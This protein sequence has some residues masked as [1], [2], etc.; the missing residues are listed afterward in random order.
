[1]FEGQTLSPEERQRVDALGA[2]IFAEPHLWD[3]LIP[4]NPPASVAPQGAPPPA[5]AR[6]GRNDPCWCGSGRKYKQCH[7]RADEAS[8]L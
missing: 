7:L 6:P 4:P 3:D 1:M 8:G 5:H 2:Q